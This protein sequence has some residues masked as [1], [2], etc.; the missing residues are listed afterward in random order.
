ML[1]AIKTITILLCLFS[2][3]L[4]AGSIIKCQAEDGS[5]TFADTRCPAGH[6]LLSHK[7]FHT[8]YRQPPVN[9]KNLEK[10]PEF[11]ATEKRSALAKNLFQAKFTQ[12]LSSISMIKISMSEYHFVNG[13][14]PQ[15]LQDLGFDASEMTSSL[16][17][18]TQVME[19]GRIRIKLAQDFGEDKQIW[20]YPKPV[21]DGTQ[22]EWICYSNF[23]KADLHMVSGAT[24]CNSRFF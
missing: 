8:T 21:M 16:I 7:K 3:S 17:T 24:L 14:W 6:T 10:M 15:N 11:P 19:Q 2:L 23:P 5:I 1:P 22:I 4:N 9:I 13:S 18:Q 20:I 12:I